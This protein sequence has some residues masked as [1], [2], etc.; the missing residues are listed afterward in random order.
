MK[1]RAG[2]LVKARR[3]IAPSIPTSEVAE[4]SPV[5][6]AVELETSLG[7]GPQSYR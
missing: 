7:A 5:S 6:I 2:R 1:E 3:H 4:R